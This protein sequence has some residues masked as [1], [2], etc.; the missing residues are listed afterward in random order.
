MFNELVL[1]SIAGMCGVI[2]GAPF[3]MIKVQLQTAA[4]GNIITTNNGIM[5]NKA[6]EIKLKNASLLFRGLIPPM[7]GAALFNGSTFAVYKPSFEFLQSFE[8]QRIP[9]T[10][11]KINKDN[12]DIFIA[13]SIA[14]F[15]ST[16]VTAPT[17]VVKI[18]MQTSRLSANKNE[19]NG[20]L[21]KS[22]TEIRINNRDK[23][24]RGYYTGFGIQLL[25]DVPSSGVYFLVY[26][27]LKDVSKHTF[28][29]NNAASELLSGG[30]A[31]VLCWFAAAPL[32]LMKTL[33]QKE[34][35][36]PLAM[37]QLKSTK[38]GDIAHDIYHKEGVKGFFRGVVPLLLRAFP[39]NATTFF[40]Y[41]ELCRQQ[42]KFVASYQ[43]PGI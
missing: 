35:R 43:T 40:V 10:F 5:E 23:L 30:V 17:E 29:V 28:G 12:L 3:D 11:F 37:R 41:E 24:F 38:V 2:I 1:G 20:L 16:I 8:Y 15:A 27:W 13:G 34:A 9:L 19:T 18:A 7:I 22:L 42:E 33:V 14:G 32:D 39:V 26:Y 4:I 6:K 31:G 21:R 25:R 36:L